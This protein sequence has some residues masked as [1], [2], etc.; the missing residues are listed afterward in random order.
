MFRQIISSEFKTHETPCW[1]IGDRGCRGSTR[2]SIALSECLYL[3]IIVYRQVIFWY[4]RREFLCW[5]LVHF[6]ASSVSCIIINGVKRSNNLVHVRA[7]GLNVFRGCW[8]GWWWLRFHI[9]TVEETR[10][11]YHYGGREGFYNNMSTICVV[12]PGHVRKG[13]IAAIDVSCWKDM[14]S[15]VFGV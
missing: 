12:S 6:L 11:A 8:R 3:S 2:N 13:W 5:G 9:S 7:T 4:H 14:F 1:V 10:W 15:W